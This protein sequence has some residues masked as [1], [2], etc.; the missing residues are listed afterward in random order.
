MT[1]KGGIV[2]LP[3]ENSD[4]SELKEVQQVDQ[5]KRQEKEKKPREKTNE[6]VEKQAQKETQPE[7][8]AN[9]EGDD[10][11][12]DIDQCTKRRTVTAA[13]TD[14]QKEGLVQWFNDNGPQ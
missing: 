4:H 10:Q 13:L 11:L 3:E 12:P 2:N 5:E 14:E 8:D 1:K 9:E 7:E 6:P